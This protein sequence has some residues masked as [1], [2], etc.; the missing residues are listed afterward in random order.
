MGTVAEFLDTTTYTITRCQKRRGQPGE[1]RLRPAVPDYTEVMTY[2][3]LWQASLSLSPAHR[4]TLARDL[5]ASLDGPAE[6]DVST[7]WIAE[8][9]SRLAGIQQ[10]DIEPI[11]W[12]QARN[13]IAD[14][15]KTQG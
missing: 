4:A 5:V 15:L 13:R 2:T 14:R 3:E 10:G 1:P 7:A 11:D 6:Q 8:I 12:A 9:G